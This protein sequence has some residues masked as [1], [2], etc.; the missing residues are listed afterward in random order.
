MT[1][2]EL[3][4][5]AARVVTAIKGRIRAAVDPVSRRLS[6]CETRI[7]ALSMLLSRGDAAKQLPNLESLVSELRAAVDKSNALEARI[8]FLET[9]LAAAS[10]L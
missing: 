3:E 4:G 8:K 2:A 7:G 5:L 6:E 1:T 10:G 9:K